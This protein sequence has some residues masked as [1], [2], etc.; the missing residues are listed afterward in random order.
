MSQINTDETVDSVGT[1]K[2]IQK[3][4]GYRWTEDSIHL[5]EFS[6]PL[7]KNDTVLDIGTGSGIIPLILA[8][9]SPVKNIVGIEIQ[10]TLAD[11]ALRNV[12]INNLS[13]RIKI[14]KKDYR[15]LKDVFKQKRFSVILSNPPYIPIKSGRVCPDKERAIARQEIFGALKELAHISKWLL[16][17]GGRFLCIYPISRLKEIISAFDKEGLEIT[18]IKFVN[19][20]EKVKLF[21]VEARKR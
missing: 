20:G 12:K 3:K 13:K 15:A 8:Y 7:S 9:K 10:E 16:K 17:S 21:L 2:I 14:L 4:K 11:L 19:S 6:L 18:R 1:F 5:A